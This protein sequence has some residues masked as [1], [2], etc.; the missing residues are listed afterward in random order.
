MQ[1]RALFFLM[2]LTFVQ[3]QA[4]AWGTLT[5][6]TIAEIAQMELSPATE[7][8]VLRILRS[9]PLVTPP[10]TPEEPN[11]EAAKPVDRLAQV[12]G[13]AD[14]ARTMPE[15]KQTSHYHFEEI[16]D[17]GQF[18][19]TLKDMTPAQ[20][21]R[22]TVIE[23]L[24]I[25]EKLLKDESLSD[26]KKVLPLK[27]LIHFVGDLHQPLHTGRLQDVGGNTISVNWYGHDTNLHSVWD[28]GMLYTG[29]AD[30]L[31]LDDPKA[32]SP[33][34][35]AQ[36]LEKTQ[37][38]SHDLAIQEKDFENWLRE[39]MDERPQAYVKDYE[40][41]QSLYLNHNLP[42]LDSRIYTSGV[43]LGRLLNGIFAHETVDARV[44][45]FHK[46]EAIVGDLLKI[47][48]FEPRAAELP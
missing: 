6:H 48:N 26:L 47:I 38:A 28:T 33:L 27:F 17:N 46:I 22:G 43:R 42:W 9:E 14:V 2:S 32:D 37:L 20:R 18:L 13:W 24:L 31:K 10:A 15:F 19:Q 25:A 40:S 36:Y 39:S 4:Q 41:N 34:L 35:Y 7:A 12:S 23:A 16:N 45:L 8:I 11:P 29:H 30:V 44:Q 3:L 1:T 5:H 21:S